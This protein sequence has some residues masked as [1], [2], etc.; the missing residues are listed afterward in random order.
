MTNEV[1]D[2]VFKT[3]LAL[4]TPVIEVNRVVY[5]CLQRFL[6]LK[7]IKADADSN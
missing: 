3:I 1:I 6:D 7:E 2:L 4:V 5:S